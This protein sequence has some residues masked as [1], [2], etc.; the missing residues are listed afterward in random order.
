MQNYR[1]ISLT[2]ILC[3]TIKSIIKDNMLAHLVDNNLLDK[4][5]HGFLLC[6]STTCQL[7]E[8]HYDWSCANDVGYSVDVVYI[9]F[10]KA[11]DTVSHCKLASELKSLISS[12]SP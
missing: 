6:H 4:N 9:D 12:T 2:C 5:Q 7:L 3:K 8:F 11:F 1:H 10:S